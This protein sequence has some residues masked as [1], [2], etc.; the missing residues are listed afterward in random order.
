MPELLHE[1]Y[2]GVSNSPFLSPA[3]A[4]AQPDFGEIYTHLL[5]TIRDLL[6]CTGAAVL[7]PSGPAVIVLAQ[8][9]P[10]ALPDQIE[11]S[12]TA[13]HLLARIAQARQP[14]LVQRAALFQPPLPS[15]AADIAW[16]GIPVFL[17]DQL[18]ACLSLARAL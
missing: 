6:S 16:L 15:A 9:G 8:F 18:H 10:H 1:P 4:G 12:A 7:L 14:V 11:L 17:D 2:A 13:Q 3:Q 5:A